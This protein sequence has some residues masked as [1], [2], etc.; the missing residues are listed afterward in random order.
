VTPVLFAVGIVTGSVVV[1]LA[2]GSVIAR[3]VEGILGRRDRHQ[4]L[5]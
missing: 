1:C 5:P 4:D 2:A 3:L